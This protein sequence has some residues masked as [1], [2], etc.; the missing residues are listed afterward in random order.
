MKADEKMWAAVTVACCAGAGVLA[1]AWGAA[2]WV[3][4][5]GMRLAGVACLIVGGALCWAVSGVLLWVWAWSCGRRWE[6]DHR[7][8]RCGAR[9]EV[10][11]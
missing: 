9:Q 7:G 2:E 8:L 11:P 4:G 3:W 6:R 10:E 1:C 5:S